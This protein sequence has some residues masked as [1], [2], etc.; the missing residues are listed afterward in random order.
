MVK[1]ILKEIAFL[2]LTIFLLSGISAT[3][4]T[5]NQTYSITSSYGPNESIKGWVNISFNGES[6][7]ATFESSLGGNISLVDLLEKNSNA[8]FGY[9]CNPISPLC[10]LPD[11]SASNG[12]PTKTYNLNANQ[13][14]YFGFNISSG[15][16]SA[17][18]FNS[19]SEL[20]FNLTSNNPE[21]E[22][23]PLEVD[24]L[25]SGQYVW[26]AYSPSATLSS[27][28]T[29]CY[30]GIS[31]VPVLIGTNPYCEEIKLNQAPEA[32]IGAYINGTGNA[33]FIMTIQEVSGQK[34][35]ATCSTSTS[36]I[37]GERQVSCNAINFPINGGD[38]YVCIS[39]TNSYVNQYQI[40][41]EP[42][43]NP[44]CG[45]SG[46]FPGNFDN[47]FEIF[48][49]TYYY[50]PNINF[51]MNDGELVKA[52]SPMSNL[53]VG[54]AN[55]ISN[56]YN[57]N[58]SRGCI[59]PVKIF[60]GVNQTINI[61]PSIS[62]NFGSYYATYSTNV[63]TYSGTAFDLQETPSQITSKGAGPQPLYFDDSG[64]LTPSKFGNQTF[65]ISLDGTNLF[66]SS[67]NVEQV[68]VIGSLTPLTTAVDYPTTFSLNTNSNTSITSF[69]WDFGDGTTQTTS[70]GNATHEYSTTGD[71]VISVNVTDTNG[72]SSSEAFNITVGSASIIIP[73]LLQQMEVNLATISAQITNFPQF[74]QDSINSVLNLNSLQA[75]LT[76]LNYSAT[77]AASEQEFDDILTSLLHMD[78]PSSIEETAS[79][80]QIV[81]Y[82][83]N[84]NLNL[85]IL[86]EIGGGTYDPNNEKG[87]TDAIISWEQQ[88]VN[89]V[90]TYNEITIIYPDHEQPIKLFQML[91][92]NTGTGNEYIIL[93]QMDNLFIE[94]KEGYSQKD[95]YYYAGLTG[96]QKEIDFST[97][98]NDVDFVSL[99]LFISPPLSDL[100]VAQFSPFNSSGQQNKLVLF[101]II[102]VI[103]LVL[104]LIAW[105]I[106]QMWYKRRY[107]TFLFKDRNQLYNLINFVEVEREKG[108]EEKDIIVK[109][110]NSGWTA[111]Q[112]TYAMKKHAG[113]RTGLPEII[114]IE[115]IVGIFK[116]KK[117]LPPSTQ[118]KT[119]KRNI[120]GMFKFKKKIVPPKTNQQKKS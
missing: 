107:E 80:S 47:D 17:E 36:G 32:S 99:P 45:Y 70:V 113:K 111:E 33:N 88:N 71:Y 98:E 19:I 94:N 53:E 62:S 5:G 90:L 96:A 34:K 87:Y 44:S 79:S 29:G 58:C 89:M 64:F 23:F 63:N 2:T 76:A 119:P 57:N 39:T 103:V 9:T 73:T 31:P 1:I 16:N 91:V 51:T 56:R 12:N 21:T 110:K 11:Y 92:S 55:Y 15:A 60:S 68:P 86:Q 18:F 43:N 14:T 81:F 65:S 37:G 97:T 22:I 82:P 77:N 35:S 49:Q 59:I 8:G 104:A 41:S 112:A 108:T 115:K 67:I 117:N 100:S 84:D 38:Y 102:I 69:N 120:L 72:E 83:E 78:I 61:Q 27:Q 48:G 24:V 25:N 66:T 85:S 26:E 52:N 40:N 101:I 20:S 7:N 54:I 10:N 116:K 13:S 4:T 42:N 50:A 75:N 28:N 6:S 114:P 46:N 3:F 93:K 95:G 74:E 106:L 109:L 118:Q 30:V 105:V